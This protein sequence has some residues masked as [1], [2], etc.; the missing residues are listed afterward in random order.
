M[1]VSMS[2]YSINEDSLQI[3][4]LQSKEKMAEWCTLLCG[5]I[6]DTDGK[7]LLPDNPLELKRKER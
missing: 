4:F 6:V 2:E 7:A 5:L 3:I 1:F